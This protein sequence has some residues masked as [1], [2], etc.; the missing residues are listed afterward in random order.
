MDILTARDDRLA[1][2]MARGAGTD[3]MHR[4]AVSLALCV[5]VMLTADMRAA[6]LADPDPGGVVRIDW[7]KLAADLDTHPGLSTG[8]RAA[9]GIACSLAI[10][11]APVDL[12]R[13]IPL[14]DGELRLA[15]CHALR[16]AFLW[17]QISRS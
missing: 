7:P 3:P 14:M 15:A 6:Y 1:E 17:P 5:D 11:G 8:E 4:A 12:A 16:R 2:A 9:L 13:A 10:A